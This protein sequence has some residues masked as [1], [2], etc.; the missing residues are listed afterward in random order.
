MITSAVSLVWAVVAFFVLAP[1]VLQSYWAERA[2]V[3][4]GISPGSTATGLLL[5]RM[6]D[7]DGKT[8]VLQQ[9]GFKQVLHCL[10]VGGGVF[11]AL[12]LNI[13]DAVLYK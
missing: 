5:L 8:P 13:A 12:S 7:P 10:V 6:A 3:E 4:L 2:L 1:K 11:D 9:F